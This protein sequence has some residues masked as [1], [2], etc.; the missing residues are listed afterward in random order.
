MFLGEGTVH[1]FSLQP[2]LSAAKSGW[3]QSWK[4]MG[5]SSYPTGY[6]SGYLGGLEQPSNPRDPSL[7]GEQEVRSHFF[8]FS[9]YGRNESS[10]PPRPSPDQADPSVEKAWEPFFATQLFRRAERGKQ[11]LHPVHFPDQ[12]APGLR[13]AQEPERR[14][15]F[16]G[17]LCECLYTSGF[18]QK[19]CYSPAEM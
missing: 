17:K 14:V 18:Y 8:L 10:C 3:A 19:S 6:P 16:W 9:M 12:G 7:R 1:A 2:P 13:K 15:L 5:K 11:Q 4:S